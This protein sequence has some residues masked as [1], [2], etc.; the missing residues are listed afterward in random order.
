MLFS[1][2]YNKKELPKPLLNDNGI[3]ITY[4]K[5]TKAIFD[6]NCFSCH[7][8]SGTESWLD[9]STYQDVKAQ[10]DIGLIKTRVID[11]SPSVMPPA[12]SLPQ[13]LKDTLQMWLNQGAL[14]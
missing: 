7:S 3:T 10:A 13:D 1:C 14:E 2:V 9:L 8:P 4:T 5:H 11:E 12:G 6:N